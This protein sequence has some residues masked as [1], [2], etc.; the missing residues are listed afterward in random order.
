MNHLTLNK[1]AGRYNLPTVWNNTLK[2]L[3]RRGDQVVVVIMS[4]A[5]PR[6]SGR[7]LKKLAVSK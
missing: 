1:D 6:P 7:C 5:L 4:P 3:G 2:K